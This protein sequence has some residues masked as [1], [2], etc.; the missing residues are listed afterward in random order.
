MSVERVCDS[1]SAPISIAF[2]TASDNLKKLKSVWRLNLP[3]MVLFES[4][5]TIAFP[6]R[7]RGDRVTMGLRLNETNP[8]ADP[9]PRPCVP[10]TTDD[11]R[12]NLSSCRQTVRNGYVPFSF[13]GL[14]VSPS[15]QILRA[16]AAI[17]RAN[18]SRAI[19]FRIPLFSKA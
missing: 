18:A 1:S 14:N 16:I 8:P 11:E 13:F 7:A 6:G 19:S 2:V 17:L 3:T 10:I 12:L 5:R 4:Q 9:L 15:F